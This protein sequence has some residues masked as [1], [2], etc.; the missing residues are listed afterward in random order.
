MADLRE[1]RCSTDGEPGGNRRG[2][3]G[4]S[5]STGFVYFIRAG[6]MRAIKIGWAND[7]EARLAALQTASHHKLHLIGYLPGS[8]A[9]EQEWHDRFRS[10][11]I[12]GEW[13]N[14]TDEIRE[15]IN[16]ALFS[17]AG[18]VRHSL[19]SLDWVR[20]GVRARRA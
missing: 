1:V 13:F 4:H 5:L 12:R 9:D 14:L 17:A 16:A 3:A 18:A 19:L 7:A 2:F 20:A 8:H 11:R 10:L 15:A 6:R